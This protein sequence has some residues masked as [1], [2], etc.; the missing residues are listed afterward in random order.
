MT[1]IDNILSGTSLSEGIYD[2]QTVILRH[3]ML[4]IDRNKFVPFIYSTWDWFVQSQDKI[5][6]NFW[7]LQMRFKDDDP[8]FDILF[9]DGYKT[10]TVEAKSRKYSIYSD[11]KNL[12]S[13]AVINMFSNVESIEFEWVQSK[14]FDKHYWSF[15]LFELLS[16]IK[17][18]KIEKVRLFGESSGYKDSSWLSDVWNKSKSELMTEYRKHGYKIRFEN[19]GIGQHY[20]H[21]SKGTFDGSRSVD[22]DQESNMCDRDCVVNCV[23]L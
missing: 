10:G 7:D 11:G 20:I 6:M 23:A 15:S 5:V 4:D 8:L 13:K 12:L 19:N 17:D 3:L 2:K 22:V 18:T 9:M 16:L 14:S 21:I 1:L